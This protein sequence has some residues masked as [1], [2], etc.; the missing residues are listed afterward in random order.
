MSHTLPF[1]SASFF[2]QRVTSIAPAVVRVRFSF[3]PVKVDPSAANDALNP[4]NYTL[5]GSHL[6][7]VTGVGVVPEDPQAVDVYANVPLASGA[8]TLFASTSIEMP[9]ATTLGT[10]SSLLFGV[11]ALEALPGI[12]GGAKNDEAGGVIRKH[13][14]L[15][16]VGK[17]WDALIAALSVGDKYNWENAISAF[18]QL[19]KST[20]SGVYLDRR[21]NDEGVARPASIGMPDDLFRRFAT[22]SSKKLTLQAVL[23]TL[24]TFYGTDAVRAFVETTA[25]SPF[26]LDNDQTLR[27]MADGKDLLEVV[28]SDDDFAQIGRATAVEVSAAITRQARA[29]GLGLF[30]RVINDKVRIYS[31]SMG[32]GST[33]SIVGG[34]AQSG[35]LFPE[36]LSIEIPD[37][38]L[39]T[40]TVPREGVARYAFTS[41]NGSQ[42]LNLR[43][44]DFVNVTCEAFQAENRG[45]FVVVDVQTAYSGSTFNHFFEVTNEGAL[46]ETGALATLEDEDFTFFRPFLSRIHSG[47][48][49]GVVAAQAAPGV[50]DV[51]LPATTQAVGRTER[52]AAY[53]PLREPLTVQ[54]VS[55]SSGVA[56]LTTATAHGLSAGP[57]VLLEGV[58]PATGS[59]PRGLNREWKLATASG[60]TL[61]FQVESGYSMTATSGTLIPVSAAASDVPGPFIWNIDGDPA[62]TSVNATLQTALSARQH[63]RIL[64]VDDATE[65][66][67]EEGYLAVGAGYSYSVYPVRYLGRASDT[68]LALDY[69]FEFPNDVP[70]QAEVTLLHQKGAFAPDNGAAAGSFYL[71]ASNAGRVAAQ[72]AIEALLGAGLEVDFSVSYPG[73]VGLGGAGLGVTGAK[74]SDKV[75]VWGSDNLDEELALAHEED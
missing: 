52:Q 53:L 67:D 24:E 32:L 49:R 18:D 68:E 73:D 42:L 4:A 72:A 3:D 30:A 11:S 39:V 15:G 31:G 47:A 61:T 28:F 37:G 50:L 8:W 70:A 34:L 19:F 74:F 10:P 75:A 43:S 64:T 13:L 21:A 29:V 56:T 23:D 9:D 66:P 69:R 17:A 26:R 58:Y 2:V 27:V 36:N 44:G 60:S 25:V 51:V 62:L 16:F 54:S 7:I 12:T 5:T 41:S 22:K 20:A 55:I 45:S 57:R 6:V 40:V 14:P 38:T 59:L 71:T 65:F 35:L 1:T 33:V 63:Y 46:A 48:G